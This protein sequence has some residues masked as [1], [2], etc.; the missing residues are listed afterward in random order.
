[1]LVKWQGVAVRR[2]IEFIWDTQW[3]KCVF[4]K[5]NFYIEVG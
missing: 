1:M 4:A 2:V 5:S 3:G